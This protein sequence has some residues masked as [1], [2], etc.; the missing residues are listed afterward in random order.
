MKNVCFTAKI[1]TWVWSFLAKVGIVALGVAWV[2]LLRFPASSNHSVPE[3]APVPAPR[4]PGRWVDSSQSSGGRPF[5]DASQANRLPVPDPVSPEIHADRVQ[6][7]HGSSSLVDVN[8]ATQEELERLPGLG[9]VLAQRIV[10]YRQA[11]GPFQQLEE[12]ERVRGIGHKRLQ[13][14]RTL[15]RLTSKKA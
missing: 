8:D 15:I 14:L 1:P 6:A 13:Q 11:N 5:P 12:L 9:T 2:I 7:G 3:K 10:A 4:P